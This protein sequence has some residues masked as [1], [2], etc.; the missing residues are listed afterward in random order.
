MPFWEIKTKPVNISATWKTI[1][2]MDYSGF[3]G[4]FNYLKIYVKMRNL[5]T[6]LERHEKKV[7]ENCTGVE[8]LKAIGEL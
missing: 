4:T 1:S 7:A 5:K 6:F 8:R 3:T 2:A